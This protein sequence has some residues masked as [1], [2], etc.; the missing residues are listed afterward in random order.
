M[1]VTFLGEKN[2][3]IETVVIPGDTISQFVI[4]EYIVLYPVL[5]I[6]CCTSFTNVLMI[7]SDNYCLDVNRNHGLILSNTLSNNYCKVYSPRRKVSINSI[8]V[9]YFK[10]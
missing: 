1:G 6:T 8:F 5:K 4:Y 7:I 3:K 9:I 2:C 10:L